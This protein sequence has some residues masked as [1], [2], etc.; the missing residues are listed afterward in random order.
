MG[1]L[2]E[3]KINKITFSLKSPLSI[4]SGVNI[5]TDKD[6]IRDSEGHPYI[7]GSAIAGVC[8]SLI[9]N[10]GIY[11]EYEIKKY[12][13]FVPNATEDSPKTEQIDSKITFYD[14]SL[15]EY[16]YTTSIRDSVSLDEYKTAI[17]GKKFDMEVVEPGAKFVTYIEQNIYSD[18]DKDILKDISNLWLNDEI[19][20]GSKTMR[21]YGEI[22]TKKIEQKVFKFDKEHVLDYI[23][24]NMYAEW[25]DVIDIEKE[26][27]SSNVFS[28]KLSLIQNGGISVL[29]NTT[30]VNDLKNGYAVPDKKQLVIRDGEKEIP[31]IPG[32]TWAGAFL[33]RMKELEPE[34]DFSILFGKVE[35]KEKIKSKIKFSESQIS[36]AIPKTH[37]RNSI[38]RYTGGAV[39]KRLFTEKTYYNGKLDLII[40]FTD[41]KN[42]SDGA[43][44][45]LAGSITDLHYGLLSIGGLTS[46]G[47]GV[48]KINSINDDELGDEDV[49]YKVKSLLEGQRNG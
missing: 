35:G 33:H 30:E 43:I 12:F 23:N 41:I 24:F 39:D 5:E 7:P 49:F 21:G 26:N 31:V 20:F 29:K 4:G 27:Y 10:K 11:D 42:I 36:G 28:I 1:R 15:K 2:I 14:A 13:G 32:T 25:S 6:I 3:K 40:T 8:R 45:A 38:D 16:K 37:T 34:E 9:E 44:N 48:F 46:I 19:C 18:D 17:S 47:R 22:T